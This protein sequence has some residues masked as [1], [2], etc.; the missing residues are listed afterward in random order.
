MPARR[1]ASANP[2]PPSFGS[3]KS[4]S[5]PPNFP[6]GLRTALTIVTSSVRPI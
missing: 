1:I 5:V 2:I 4:L 6:N 3:V